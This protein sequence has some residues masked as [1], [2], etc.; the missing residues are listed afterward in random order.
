MK[1]DKMTHLAYGNVSKPSPLMVWGFGYSLHSCCEI[2]SP[3]VKHE[4]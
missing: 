4:L 2:H 3:Q 1:M